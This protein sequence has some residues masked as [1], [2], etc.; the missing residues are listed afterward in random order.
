[1]IEEFLEGPGGRSLLDYKLSCF[2]G[3]VEMVQI[4][5]DRF[6]NHVRAFVGRDFELLDF[7]MTY[8]HYRGPLIGP[9]H[10]SGMLEMAELLARG[11]PFLRVD[12]YEI[13]RLVFGELT[14][15]P[16]A[17]VGLFEPP[18]CDY[19]LGQLMP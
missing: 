18:E 11:Q 7:D 19:K 13:G 4:D 9:A 12:C 1:M 3:R 8:P 5:V 2:R 10:F 14:L 6:T 16:A 17:G 15:H